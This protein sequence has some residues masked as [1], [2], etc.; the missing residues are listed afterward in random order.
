VTIPTDETPKGELILCQTQDGRTRIECRFA[1]D[2]IWLTQTPM[3]ELFQTTLQNINLHLQ[4]IYEEDELDPEATSAR[5][6][7]I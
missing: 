6:P 2:T 7:R 3:A 5:S 4:N 1:G